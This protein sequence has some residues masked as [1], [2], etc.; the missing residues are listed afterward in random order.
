MNEPIFFKTFQVVHES[1]NKVCKFRHTPHSFRESV[2][3]LPQI[4]GMSCQY[5]LV[6]AAKSAANA[7]RSR[8][9]DYAICVHEEL[10]R[11]T[12]TKKAKHDY[13]W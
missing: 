10:Q 12:L 1:L 9:R 11:A 6:I 4:H 5:G 13:M 2:G 8:S 3:L 7:Q